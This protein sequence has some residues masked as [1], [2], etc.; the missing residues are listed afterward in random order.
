MD[1]N[2]NFSFKRW[3]M[4]IAGSILV[5]AQA[6]SHYQL[7][8]NISNEMDKLKDTIHQDKVDLETF[9][10]RKTE[11]FMM[12]SKLDKLSEQVTSIK[13]FI[14]TTYG[15]E[16]KMDFESD[17]NLSCDPSLPKPKDII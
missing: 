17:R 5:L 14:K 9:F 2:D 4:G 6:L 10:V 7:S 8:S 11:I 12:V 16:A 1:E 15:F 3:E 13:S